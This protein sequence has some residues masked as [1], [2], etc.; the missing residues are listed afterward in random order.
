MKAMLSDCK[1]LLAARKEATAGSAPAPGEAHGAGNHAGSEETLVFTAQSN[2][3]KHGQKKNRELSGARA[4][5]CPCLLRRVR[6]QLSRLDQG[7]YHGLSGPPRL[8]PQGLINGLKLQQL[9]QLNTKTVQSLH[10]SAQ[11]LWRRFKPA[12]HWLHPVAFSGGVPTWKKKI[13]LPNCRQVPLQL[14]PGAEDPSLLK[15]S[16]STLRAQPE[17]RCLQRILLGAHDQQN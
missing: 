5:P 2:E 7:R 15:I 8:P 4:Q 1:C 14:H 17:R 13:A 3:L 10:T 12:C 11:M 6:A 16:A 9:N